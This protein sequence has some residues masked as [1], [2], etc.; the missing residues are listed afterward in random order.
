MAPKDTR[1]FAGRKVRS[2][3]CAVKWLLKRV[4]RLAC[5]HQGSDLAAS[6]MADGTN[7]T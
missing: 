2:L 7:L 1:V 6:R 5:L 3:F 4:L